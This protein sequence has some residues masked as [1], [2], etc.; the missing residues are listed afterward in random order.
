MTKLLLRYFCIVEYNILDSFIIIR[1]VSID[2]KMIN[3]TSSSKY[4]QFEQILQNCFFL[5]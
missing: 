2:T 1:M 5:S 3:L 4:S